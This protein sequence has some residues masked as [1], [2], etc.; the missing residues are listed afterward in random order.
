MDGAVLFNASAFFNSTDG[1]LIS[2]IENAGS[3][4]YNIDSEIK[5]FEGNLIAYLSESTRIDFNWLYVESEMQG[6]EWGRLYEEHHHKSYNPSD[7]SEEVKKL[8]ENKEITLIDVRDI[9]E[10]WKE[11]TVENSKHIPRGMLE[12]WLDPE[13]SYYKANKIKDLKKKSPNFKSVI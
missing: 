7:V 6:L 8:A 2:N 12:F 10:L 11:G 4:N 5:G 1:L 13:S 9:R 3:V